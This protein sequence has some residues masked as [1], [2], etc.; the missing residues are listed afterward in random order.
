MDKYE[1]L[2]TI[3]RGAFAVVRLVRRKADDALLA[4]KTMRCGMAELSAK[5]RMEL[6]QEVKLL[7]TLQHPNVV[8]FIDNLIDAVRAPRRAWLGC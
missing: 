3:G 1:E 7:H 8:G 4:C 6:T 2:K 5:E